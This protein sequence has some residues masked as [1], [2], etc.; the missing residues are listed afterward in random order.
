[1]ERL[2]ETRR[3]AGNNPVFG[4]RGTDTFTFDIPSTEVLERVDLQ[5]GPN[6]RGGARVSDRPLA[7]D[8][9]AGKRVSVNWWFDGGAPWAGNGSIEYTVKAH[10]IAMTAATGRI[11]Q[12]MQAL[13]NGVCGLYL[14]EV[15]GPVQV[16]FNESRQFEPA[17]SIKVLHLFHAIKEVEAGT[18][19]LAEQT[20]I[21]GGD[22]CRTGDDD[23]PYTR[24]TLDET[25]RRMM[26]NSDN[27]ATEATRRRFGKLAIRATAAGLA[28]NNT[29]LIHSLGCGWAPEMGGHN[30]TTLVDLGRLYERTGAANPFPTHAADFTRLIPNWVFPEWTMIVD[31]EAAAL[32]AQ[33][34]GRLTAA[35]IQSFKNGMRNIFKAGGYEGPDQNAAGQ[36]VWGVHTS[37]VG[38]LTLPVR[39]AGVVGT[40]MFCHGVFVENGS[41]PADCGTARVV[42]TTEIVREPI[43]EALRT[44]Q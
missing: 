43:R 22:F 23:E 28:M 24:E 40:R 17:S 20:T 44:F 41:V 2:N 31:Q 3:H 26:M 33:T 6:T 16:A 21:P 29:S 38:L 4:D 34:P 15:N 11:L 37:L 18:A 42:G 1:M 12:R 39:R 35:E 10:T 32:E 8:S 13:T 36:S 9:G 7:F 14:K 5:I 30:R 25:L 19:T 27:S